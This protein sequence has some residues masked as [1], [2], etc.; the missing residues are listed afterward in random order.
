MSKAR[1]PFSARGIPSSVA[2]TATLRRHVEALEVSAKGRFEAGAKKAKVR[3]FKEFYDGAASWSRVERIIARVEA[4]EEEPTPGSSLPI[5]QAADRR[6][7][8]RT[9]TAGAAARKITSNPGRPISPPPRA[10]RPP[11]ISSACSCMPSL[12][13]ENAALSSAAFKAARVSMFKVCT[14][15]V[16]RVIGRSNRNEVNKD[17]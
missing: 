9:F 13:T 12:S 16:R 4:G 1:P 14:S 11:P 17:G 6:R 7:S 15:I 5:S 10:A 8:T 2:P 3:R